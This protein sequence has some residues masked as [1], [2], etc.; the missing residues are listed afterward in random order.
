MVGI[1]PEQF[2]GMTQWQLRACIEAHGELHAARVE[3]GVAMAWH[4]AAFQRAG[5]LPK[6]S[7]ILARMKQPMEKPF[8]GDIIGVMKTQLK[9]RGR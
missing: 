5:K 2:W 1:L 6:L 9:R 4:N 8:N 3:E 7:D